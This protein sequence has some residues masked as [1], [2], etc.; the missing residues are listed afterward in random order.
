MLAALVLT[1]ECI[2]FNYTNLVPGMVYWTT[3]L[4]V[5]Y[6]AFYGLVKCRPFA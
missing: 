6:A 3:V 1:A 4:Q 2:W 5:I